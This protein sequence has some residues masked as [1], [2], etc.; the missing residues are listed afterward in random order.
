MTQQIS[1]VVLYEGDEYDLISAKPWPF[2]PSRH[3]LHPV[4]LDTACHAGFFCKYGV[5]SAL[6]VLETLA[7]GCKKRR[8]P[9]FNGRRAVKNIGGG[10][11]VYSGLDLHLRYTGTIT[12]GKGLIW[13]FP[14]LMRGESGSAYQSVLK[15]DFSRG[16]LRM[17]TDVSDLLGTLKMRDEEKWD[18]DFRRG[19]PG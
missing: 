18:D 6:L 13:P 9:P 11:H 4:Q 15:L 16:R 14:D 1:D 12:L 3:G 5:R 10:Y 8:P 17:V 7:I 19:G 2:D